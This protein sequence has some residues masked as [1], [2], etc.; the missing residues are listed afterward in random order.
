[1][2]E[3]CIFFKSINEERGFRISS[4][5][6]MTEYSSP[7]DEKTVANTLEYI[8]KCSKCCPFDEKAKWFFFSLLPRHLWVIC[9]NTFSTFHASCQQEF[10]FLNALVSEKCARSKFVIGLFEEMSE[11]P[12]HCTPLNLYAYSV[13][14]LMSLEVEKSDEL[15]LLDNIGSQRMLQVS[16]QEHCC[17]IDWATS[18]DLLEDTISRFAAMEPTTEQALRAMAAFRLVLYAERATGNKGPFATLSEHGKAILEKIVAMKRLSRPAT[19][20][21]FIPLFRWAKSN[22]L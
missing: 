8:G 11:L 18:C 9:A 21:A 10:V 1:M 22:L 13:L 16:K 4:L 3:V 20:V 17:N 7:Y 6:Q 15:S 5:I 14:K 2:G 19:A 12:V